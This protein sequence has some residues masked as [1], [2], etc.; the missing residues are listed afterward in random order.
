MVELSMF[1]HALDFLKGKTDGYIVTFANMIIT[2]KIKTFL[3]DMWDAIFARCLL[4]LMLEK[5][6]SGFYNK[7]TILSVPNRHKI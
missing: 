3:C 1:N 7:R 2:D 6:D 4:I 5:F